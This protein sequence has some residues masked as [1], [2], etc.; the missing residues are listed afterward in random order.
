RA[1]DL[2]R[3]SLLPLEQFRVAYAIVARTARRNSHDP[4]PLHDSSRRSL[5][6]RAAERLGATGGGLRKLRVA[7]QHP[8]AGELRQTLPG[9]R[10]RVGRD[11]RTPEG[12]CAGPLH[13]RGGADGGKITTAATGPEGD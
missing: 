4:A 8:R 1:K 9:A 13:R 6:L 12:L 2:P 11:W 5:C 10:R 7:W 3:R